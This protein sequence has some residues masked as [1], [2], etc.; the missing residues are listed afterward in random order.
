VGRP[1]LLADAVL[2]LA[3]DGALRAR[4]VAGAQRFVQ[5]FSKEHMASRYFS[6]Y[7]AIAG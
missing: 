4:L 6:L 7:E 2:R 5:G 3:G 1:D